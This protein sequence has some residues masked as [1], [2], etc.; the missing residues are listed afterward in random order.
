MEGWKFQGIIWKK[1][2][3][4]SM[5]VNHFRRQNVL[6]GRQTVNLFCTKKKR[7]FNAVA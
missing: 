3:F 5:K 4:I 2:E 7:N 6:N 1:P